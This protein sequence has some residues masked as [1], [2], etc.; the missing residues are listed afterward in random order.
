MHI[1]SYD[2][3]VADCK[4]AYDVDLLAVHKMSIGFVRFSVQ[5]YQPSRH[6]LYGCLCL[7]VR[8]PGTDAP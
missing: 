5:C 4:S 2:A 7:C 6:T 3:L 8:F 1:E